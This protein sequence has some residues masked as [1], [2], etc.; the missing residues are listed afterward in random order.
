MTR[1]TFI[2]HTG[3]QHEV[4]MQEGVSIMQASKPHPFA[5]EGAC[6]GQMGCATCHVII[7][8]PWFSRL[9]PASEKEEAVL[10]VAFNITPTSRL[11]CQVTVTAELEGMVVNLPEAVDFATAII[12]A[13]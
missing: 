2:T 13:S 1:M 4:D 9:P 10:D 7:D 11:G 5:L 3:E 6:G 12:A 8:E